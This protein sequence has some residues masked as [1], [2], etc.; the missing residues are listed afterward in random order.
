MLGNQDLEKIKKNKT[1]G[2]ATTR[3]IRA[4]TYKIP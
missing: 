3:A 1:K 4:R 2:K